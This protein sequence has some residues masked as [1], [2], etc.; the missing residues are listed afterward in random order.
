MKRKKADLPLGIA[1]LA[2]VGLVVVI[3][4]ALLL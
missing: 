1:L 3:L 4:G 2:I